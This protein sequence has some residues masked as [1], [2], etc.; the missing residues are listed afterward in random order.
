MAGVGGFS[1]VEQQQGWAGEEDEDH[2]AQRERDID[3]G[4]VA[5]A[6]GDAGDCGDDKTT[7]KCR[8][9]NTEQTSTARAAS[10]RSMARSGLDTRMPSI[11]R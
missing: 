1:E 4:Q 9:F 6:A 11:I 2:E 3:V 5:H 10:S 8:S 7:V